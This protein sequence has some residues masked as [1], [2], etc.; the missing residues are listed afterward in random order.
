MTTWGYHGNPFDDATP[1]AARER[2]RAMVEKSGAFKLCGAGCGR[3][4]KKFSPYEFCMGCRAKKETERK[5]IRAH[6]F[7]AYHRKAGV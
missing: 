6:K 7:G 5:M 3:R 2:A 4:M 1:E